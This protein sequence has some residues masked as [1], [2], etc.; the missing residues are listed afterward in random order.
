MPSDVTTKPTNTSLAKP[1]PSTSALRDDSEARSRTRAGPNKKAEARAAKAIGVRA[2][3][4]CVTP[5]CHA[6]CDDGGCTLQIVLAWRRQSVRFGQV[7][8]E[9]PN[10]QHAEQE[11]KARAKEGR[12]GPSSGEGS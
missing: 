6:T 11:G 5:V 10:H 3:G 4:I 9:E 7:P 2:S 12:S 8:L 1:T